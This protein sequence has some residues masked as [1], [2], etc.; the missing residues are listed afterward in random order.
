MSRL[1]VILMMIV[2]ALWANAIIHLCRSVIVVITCIFRALD[3]E[4]EECLAQ[5]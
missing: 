5:G 4:E 1:R 2:L 3:D